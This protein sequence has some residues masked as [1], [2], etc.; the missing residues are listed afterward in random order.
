MIPVLQKLRQL[1]LLALFQLV[2][3]FLSDF[4]AIYASLAFCLCA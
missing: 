2:L 3:V 4:V 1:D